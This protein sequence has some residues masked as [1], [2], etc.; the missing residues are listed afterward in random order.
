MT[1]YPFKHTSR[2][3]HT[4]TQVLWFSCYAEG[5]QGKFLWTW[6]PVKIRTV[7]EEKHSTF[8]ENQHN[9]KPLRHIGR[10]DFQLTSCPVRS[11]VP[12]H[13]TCRRA[14]THTQSRSC[15]HTAPFKGAHL[16]LAQ[17]PLSLV[18]RKASLTMFSL[19]CSQC[20][21]SHEG[22]RTNW[23]DLQC[24]DRFTALL[25]QTYIQWN[26]YSISVTVIYCTCR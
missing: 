18:R 16:H 5:F 25:M 14:G 6:N 9:G 1:T 19:F 23:G 4:H 17:T 12:L 11:H 13:I 2:L 26:I 3:T 7:S 24:H 8:Q 15:T 10:S 20:D 22:L 21:K